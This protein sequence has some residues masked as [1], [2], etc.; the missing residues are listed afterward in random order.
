MPLATAIERLN[1]SA[2]ELSAA[3]EKAPSREGFGQRFG[4]KLKE[5]VKRKASNSPQRHQERV[6]KDAQRYRPLQQRPHTK[7]N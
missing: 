2:R 5:A 1:A 3:A 4:Q 7:S 6:E